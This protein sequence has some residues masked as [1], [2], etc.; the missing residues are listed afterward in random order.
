MTIPP[1]FIPSKDIDI[2]IELAAQ[3]PTAFL[4]EVKV[5]ITG[6]VSISYTSYSLN[7]PLQ[8]SYPLDP[9]RWLPTVPTAQWNTKLSS[10]VMSEVTVEVLEAPANFTIAFGNGVLAIDCASFSSDP[11][12]GE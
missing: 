8:S 10:K 11:G 3:G 2:Y 1:S 12:P 5:A 7:G 6:A 4:T 9:E